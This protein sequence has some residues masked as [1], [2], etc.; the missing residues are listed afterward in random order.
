MSATLT[1]RFLSFA[2]QGGG[3]LAP[4][5][6]LAAFDL[7]AS[8][9]PDALEL[10]VQMTRDGEIVVIHD[11]TVDRVTNGHGPVAT[12][13]LAELQRLDAGYHFTP[14]GGQ[15]YPFRGQGVC[16][17]TLR[18]VFER[19][20]TLLI[21]IDLKETQAG[22]EAALWR[23]I[24]QAQAIHRVIVGSFVCSSLRRFRQLTNGVVPTSA[25]PGEVAS[26]LL[27]QRLRATRGLH[28]AYLA[29]QVPETRSGIRIVS[30]AFVR[31]AHSLDLAVHVWTV[32]ERADMERL[33]DWGVDGIMT[34]RPDTLADVLAQRS[35]PALPNATSTT[36]NE[37][38]A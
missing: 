9:A 27:R 8:F 23:A 21:N 36:R 32:N 13:T 2:H 6:T 37:G 17:P 12:Y 29:F 20:P 19:F 7:G 14:D 10:D 22:K 1:R 26:F 31:A 24:Q 28:P 30:P 35:Q 34:D 16:I 18:E 4:E 11:P 25:C 5:N 3:L 33:L 38:Q 15:S